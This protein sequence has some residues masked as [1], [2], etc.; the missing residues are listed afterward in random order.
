MLPPLLRILLDEPRLLATHIANYSDLIRQETGSI[1]SRLAQRVGLTIVLAGSVFLTVT[2]LGIALMLY[3]VSGVSHW[4]LWLV[5]LV[6]LVASMVAGTMLMNLPREKGYPRTRAQ[7]DEDM[8][9]LG[10]KDLS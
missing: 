6:P 7:F 2:F 3:A 10:L 1:Q 4:L 9:V 8:Q 5:P